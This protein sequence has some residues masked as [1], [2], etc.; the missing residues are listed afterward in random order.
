M[1]HLVNIQELAA[2]DDD[3]SLRH[4]V[5]GR[6]MDIL[7]DTNFLIDPETSPSRN[8]KMGHTIIYPTGRTTGHAHDGMEEVYFVVGG[9][10]VMQVGEDEFAIKMGD[11][12][13]VPPGEF[14]VTFQRGNLPLTILWV[15]G[16][17]GADGDPA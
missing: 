1:K 5:K 4:N 10:G 3:R 6:A 8:L 2:D 12:F 14:H 16:K 15:T 11:A 7:R 17:V 13:Y 9:E